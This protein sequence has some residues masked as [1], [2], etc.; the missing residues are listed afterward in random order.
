MPSTPQTTGILATPPTILARAPLPDPGDRGLKQ[1]DDC[2]CCL[3]ASLPHLSP[4]PRVTSPATRAHL[5]ILRSPPQ[6]DANTL[7]FFLLKNGKGMLQG[8]N[9]NRKR[10]R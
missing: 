9:Q 2:H 6:T 5:S 7:I 8:L 3:D 10:E 4:L 1:G